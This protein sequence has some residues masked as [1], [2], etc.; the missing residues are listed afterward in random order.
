[1]AEI[2]DIVALL[3]AFSPR[4]EYRFIYDNR[5][6]SSTFLSIAYLAM[7]VRQSW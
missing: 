1:M 5:I 2:G 3:I 7:A 6:K 4:M